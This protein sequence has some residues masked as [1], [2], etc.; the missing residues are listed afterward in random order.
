M[1]RLRVLFISAAWA[2]LSAAGYAQSVITV[3]VPE[4][5]YAAN[6]RIALTG[7]EDEQIFYSFGE[8]R[9][10]Q[11]TEY[12]I[13]FTLSAIEGE[14]RAYTLRVEARV[15]GET[16][17]KK[18]FSYL[19]D[20][21]P[22]PAPE[23]SLP[24]GTYN[25]PI[26]ISLLPPLSDSSGYSYYVCVNG[27]GNDTAELWSGDPIVLAAEEGGVVSHTVKAFAEDAAGNLS[28]LRVW[29]YIIDT[30]ETSAAGGLQI[31]SPVP[32]VFGNRQY[33]VIRSS[34]SRSNASS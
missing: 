10:P 30:S 26:A 4:G 5:S 14:E 22:P 12:L 34:G 32:G 25:S 16:V 20:K 17:R 3:S 9:N 18:E 31:L 21:R 23:V 1:L 19:I 15:N 6:Q 33:L 29:N 13:P 8:S 7:G 2:V 27:C 24:E 11:F 28:D